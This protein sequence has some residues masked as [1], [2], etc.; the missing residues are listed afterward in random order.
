MS[1]VYTILLK[2]GKYE[3][4]RVLADEISSRTPFTI[5]YVNNGTFDKLEHA[6]MTVKQCTSEACGIE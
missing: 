5:V 3:V 2:D 6:V 1:D 4:Y